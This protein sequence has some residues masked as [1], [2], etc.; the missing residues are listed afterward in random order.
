MRMTVMILAVIGLVAGLAAV[1]M[2][3]A[4]AAST[5]RDKPTSSAP[6]ADNS[7]ER[8]QESVQNGDWR[9]AVKYLEKSVKLNPRDAD[10][11]N[12]LAYSYRRMGMLDPA[13][14]NYAKALDIDPGHKG[15]HEYVGEAYLMVGDLE[16]AERHLT[17]LR[18]IC[19]GGCNEA[20]KLKKSIVRYKDSNDKQAML[21]QDW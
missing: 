10:A 13:F 5:K 15:A 6:G 16:N 21:D 9:L 7:F 17:Q 1:P 12:L 19:G 4:D 20:M 11:Y 14:A 18:D 8:G 3:D 2:S